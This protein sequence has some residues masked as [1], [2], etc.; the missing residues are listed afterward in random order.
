MEL[1]YTVMLYK[2]GT[3]MVAFETPAESS[4][5]AVKRVMNKAFEMFPDTKFALH[6]YEVS[7][8]QTTIKTERYLGRI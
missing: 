7:D 6:G 1:K 5:E 8:G 4:T 2:K 3:G